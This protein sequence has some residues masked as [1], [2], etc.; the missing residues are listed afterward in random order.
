MFSLAFWVL[1]AHSYG[2]KT[3]QANVYLLATSCLALLN[4]FVSCVFSFFLFL[5]AV[6]KEPHR[7]CLE[8]QPPNGSPGTGS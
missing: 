3:V 2:R 7:S 6:G 1:S 8:G 5:G 4:A